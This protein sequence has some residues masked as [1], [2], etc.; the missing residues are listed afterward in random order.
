MFLVEPW[1]A[2]DYEACV[3]KQ[4]WP[5]IW[6]T[7]HWGHIWLPNIALTNHVLLFQKKTNITNGLCPFVYRAVVMRVFPHA[8]YSS[9][10]DHTQSTMSYCTLKAE[11]PLW[12]PRAWPTISE[13][14]NVSGICLLLSTNAPAS[15][16]TSWAATSRSL[17]WVLFRC[18][19]KLE[20]FHSLSYQFLAACME[21]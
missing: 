19:Q 3:C 1:K 15:I 11:R 6:A 7:V 21:Y 5:I 13:D 14:K 12:R 8:E 9:S 17:A 16:S 10:D 4:A 2:H 20:F 18:T